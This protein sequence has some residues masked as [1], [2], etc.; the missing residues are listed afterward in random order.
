MSAKARVVAEVAQGAPVVV[1]AHSLGAVVAAVAV[2]MRRLEASRFVLVEPALYD[3]ARGAE[4]IEHHIGL[5]AL[6]RHR[7]QNG[8]LYGYWEIVSPLMFGQPASPDR[9][10]GEHAFVERFAEMESPWG[11]GIKTDLFGHTPTLVVTGAWS[12]EYE[13]IA[14]RL[15]QVGAQHVQLLGNKHRVQDHP[16]FNAL[17]DAFD[18]AN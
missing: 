5:V 15:V 6:A 16:D 10:A 2:R 8:D 17:V 13:V 1:V 9:W 4:P 7:A 12:D 11:H 14:D 18:R 3:L